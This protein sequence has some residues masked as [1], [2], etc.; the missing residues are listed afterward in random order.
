MVALSGTLS[1]QICG[2]EH[3]IFFSPELQ[4]LQLHLSE[5]SYLSLS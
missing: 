4:R 1:Y 3:D 5:T 2:G